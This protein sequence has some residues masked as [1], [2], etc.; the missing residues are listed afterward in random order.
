[1]AR[2]L[3]RA[4]LTMALASRWGGGGAAA[5][6]GLARLGA[7]RTAVARLARAS[8]A[9]LRADASAP[10]A[11]AAGGG[12]GGGGRGSAA[13]VQDDAARGG[14]A[15][16]AAQGSLDLAPPR[17]TRDFY[18]PDM[19]VRNWLFG[20]WRDEALGHGFEEYDAPVMESEALYIR[21]AGEEVTQQLYNFDDK[22]GRRMALRPEMTPSLARMVLAQRSTLPTPVKWFAIPQCWRYERTTRGRRREHYQWNMD[23]W[24]V[25]TV[26]AEAELLSACTAFC[27]RVGLGPADV[28]VRISSRAAL[29]EL[30]R[31]LGVPDALF[32]RTCV[33]V[34][35]L[36]K[37][38]GEEV[39]VQLL[40]LGL[41]DGVCTS[42]FET[43]RITTIEALAERLGGESEAV[44]QLRLLFEL[45]QE[46]G[47]ADWLQLDLS[48]VRGLS[49]YTGVVFE[50]FDRKGELRAIF[51]GGRYD[52]LLESFGAE[53]MPA[54]GFGFGDA[55]IAEL[56]R[57]KGLLPSFER[58]ASGVDAVVLALDP[59]LAPH[60]VR[61]ASTLRAAGRRVDLVLEP[62]KPKWAIK[63]AE[64]LGAPALVLIGKD[65]AERGMVSVK[66]LDKGEQSELPVEQL[67]DAIPRGADRATADGV[68]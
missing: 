57:D 67:V 26:H 31:A 66:L 9:A 7:P 47:Y 1:M 10:P 36:D 14:A 16:G 2:V 30:M 11:A 8:R 38:G 62:K 65:E 23:V 48:V 6:A 44:A 33:L 37:I 45:A 55:V 12:G 61:A 41:P 56:L 18:P 52:R 21:K 29:S 49:Y 27:T 32:T 51:G 15:D 40:Q 25:P 22:Q 43:M 4:L 58:G 24:G 5:A 42:L 54:V 68:R 17:G 59:A 50:G 35:K 64:R 13:V 20:K 28:G 34:D 3:H 39:R 53:P 46:Y 63:H 60:A 19:R